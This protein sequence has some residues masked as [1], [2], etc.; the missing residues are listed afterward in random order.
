MGGRKQKP[1]FTTETLHCDEHQTSPKTF[2]QVLETSRHR[3]TWDSYLTHM[4]QKIVFSLLI[5]NN[6]SAQ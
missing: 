4:T 1:L 6:S 5:P 3:K 2:L